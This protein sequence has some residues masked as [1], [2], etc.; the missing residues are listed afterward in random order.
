MFT[1]RAGGLEYH[2]I[3]LTITR[4]SLPHTR[5]CLKGKYTRCK[6]AYLS[7]AKRLC[8]NLDLCVG[9]SYVIGLYSSGDGRHCQPTI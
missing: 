1:S 7:L 5:Q 2:F 8:G 4:R 9:S 3:H 6:G